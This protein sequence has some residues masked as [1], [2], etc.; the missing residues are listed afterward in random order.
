[1]LDQWNGTDMLTD[2]FNTQNILIIPGCIQ[3][4]LR[5]SQSYFLHCTN[6]S[7]TYGH[8]IFHVSMAAMENVFIEELKAQTRGNCYAPSSPVRAYGN[9]SVIRI[10]AGIWFFDT[11]LSVWLAQAHRTKPTHLH[12]DSCRQTLTHKP[13]SRRF[14][15]ILLESLQPL[16]LISSDGSQTMTSS[17]ACK[18]RRWA[19]I[20]T[21][22][23]KSSVKQSIQE[24]TMAY[25]QTFA[26]FGCNGANIHDKSD[27]YKQ[28]PSHAIMTII[29]LLMCTSNSVQ[30]ATE[31]SPCVQ[32]FII[33]YSLVRKKNKKRKNA[34]EVHKYIKKVKIN[35]NNKNL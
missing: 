17:W 8:L 1:M 18:V 7:T 19:H 24:I 11:R 32:L 2:V 26:I 35:I 33:F 9:K 10:W 12:L 13:V 4:Q 29:L 21:H 28:N 30:S 16:W 15:G 27:N 22:Y 5:E 6:S 34:T 31:V 25:Y 3:F 14:C 20:N 23:Q